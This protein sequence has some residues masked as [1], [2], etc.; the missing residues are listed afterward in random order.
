[1]HTLLIFKEGRSGS[2]I[3][4]GLKYESISSDIVRDEDEA[5]LHIL[6]KEYDAVIIKDGP[7]QMNGLKLCREIR[8]LRQELPIFLINGSMERKKAEKIAQGPTAIINHPLPLENLIKTLKEL[9]FQKIENS[10]TKKELKN[11]YLELNLETRQV[12]RGKKCVILRNK[13]FAL[14]EFLML[15]PGKILNRNTI[16]EQVWDRNANILTNTIDVHISTLRKK[17]DQGF[18]KKLI[19]T[20]H[21]VGYLLNIE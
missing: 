8:S 11:K 14:L 10:F 20:V 12:T 6:H 3:K 16:L 15:T 7:P 21:C 4:K 19:E 5:I 1:M 2:L 13:E 18:R 17:I 9:K